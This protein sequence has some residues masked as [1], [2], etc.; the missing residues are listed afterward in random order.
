VISQRF[1]VERLSDAH[2]RSAFSCGNAALDRYLREQAGQDLRRHLS[3][4][5]VLV[6]TANGG[7]AGYYTLSAFLIEPRELPLAIAKRLPR[8]SV[9][10]TLIGRFAV[11]VRYRGRGL[12]GTLFANALTR[13]VDASAII[14]SMAI[15]VDAKDDQARSFY[16]HYSFQRFPDDEYRLFLPMDDAERVARIVKA[17]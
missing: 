17:D 11:D 4:V 2:D 8:R 16:E 14:A 12:G 10:A 3:T 5:Y 15:I 7:V 9:P 1:R 6:D 13:A